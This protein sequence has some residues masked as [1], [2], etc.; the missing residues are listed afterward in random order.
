MAPDLQHTCYKCGA[1]FTAPSNLRICQSCRPVS[2]YNKPIFFK[3]DELTPR[4][5][6]IL[7]LLIQGLS[8]KEI[9]SALLLSEGTVKEYFSCKIFL[10]LGV[11]N[12]VSAAM[13]WLEIKRTTGASPSV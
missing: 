11:K 13:A 6:Q 2:K 12:R 10:K 4:E 1:V 9:G 5:M 8:N 3:G 7:D